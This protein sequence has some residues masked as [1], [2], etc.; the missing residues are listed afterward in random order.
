MTEFMEADFVEVTVDPA[1]VRHLPGTSIEIV[2]HPKFARAPDH[3]LF[4]FDGTLSLIREGWPDIMVPL[5]VDVL[6]DTQTDES[7]PQLEQ[8]V[9]QFVAE[10]TGKQTIY[11]MIR[12]VEEVTRRGGRP[13]D[14]QHYKQ[15]YVDRL[16][17]HIAARR[18]ALERGQLAPEELMV[19]D[20]LPL[21]QAL[22]DRGV[23]LYLASG[24]D[25]ADVR[26]EVR[27]LQLADFFGPRVHGAI[28][29]YKSFSK[30]KV[31]GQ[32]LREHQLQ[33]ER[34]LGFGDGFVEIQNVKSVGGT[35]VGVASDEQGRSGKADAWKRDRLL[36][37]GA[38]LLIPDYQEHQALL[39]FIWNAHATP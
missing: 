36:G 22:R 28:A 14:P 27:L 33:G 19:P 9:R 25:E 38:D 31:I 37:A 15:A 24:T 3:A 34:L 2:R 1:G 21:L 7:V 16:S 11:Q 17:A 29:D 18:T 30:E 23:Q 4:D 10:L 20:S 35:A 8:V 5:M 32:I 26:E 39:D 12:L 6:V 13:R